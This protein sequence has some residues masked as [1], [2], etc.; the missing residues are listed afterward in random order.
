LSGD[1]DDGDAEAGDEPEPAAESATEDISESVNVLPAEPYE[2]EE[3]GLA[4][5]GGGALT[6][7]TVLSLDTEALEKLAQA[8][9]VLTVD[10]S[11]DQEVELCFDDGRANKC[12]VRGTRTYTMSIPAGAATL[13][14]EPQNPETPYTIT[15][16]R[17]YGAEE[18][19]DFSDA[20]VIDIPEPERDDHVT[21]T[22]EASESGYVLLAIP[23]QKGWTLTV[24]GETVQAKAGDYGM[25]AF[26]VSE[27]SHT[28][29]MNF[30][31]P[32]FYE[33]LA[34]SLI[35]LALWIIGLVIVARRRPVRSDGKQRT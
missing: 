27:G 25:T 4:V 13:T 24:D 20:A 17:T 5:A 11:S 34:I 29:E 2:P 32:Y 18:V 19:S 22:I 1:S 26:E 14:I 12:Y 8:T 21:G 15:G 6:G 31:A 3:T 9:I 10:I 28:F 23:Y 35:S 16:V 30:V 7:P 33:G